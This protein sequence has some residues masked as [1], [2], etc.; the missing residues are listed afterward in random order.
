MQIAYS[1][2][3]EY[4]AFDF[5]PDELA[6]RLTMIGTAVERITPLYERFSGVIIGRVEQVEKHRQQTHLSI[7]ALNT[8][9]GRC[10]VVC[11]APN[12]HPGQYSPYAPPGARLPGGKTVS[13]AEIAGVASAGFLCSEAEMGLSEEGDRL[14]V[15]DPEKAEAGMDVWEFLAL[16]DWT[17]QFELTPN[18]PDC[19]SA[20]GIAREI[21]A[22]AGTKLRRPTVDVAEGDGP[23]AERVKIEIADREGCP[24]YAA[25]VIDN[26]QIAPSPF[27]LKRR[28]HSAGIRAINNIVDITNYVMMETGQPLHA[29]DLAKFKKP[30]VVVRAARNGEP[31]ATLDGETRRLSADAV[32]ITD[33]KDAVA[34]GGVMG[35][36]DSE[37]SEETKTVLLESAYF[38]PI[39]IRRT[40]KFLGLDTESAI[41]FEK[42]VDPNGVDFALHRAAALLADLAGGQVLSGAVDCY[43]EPIE[44]LRINVRPNRVNKLIGID[45]ASPKM[46]DILSSLEFGVAAGKTIAV[47]VPT[48]RPDVTREVDLI[49][50]IARISNYEEI[51]V[52]RQA[53]GRIPTPT[54]PTICFEAKLREILAGEGLYEV[55]TNSLVD[56]E[57]LEQDEIKQAIRIKNPLSEELSVMRTS[58]CGPLLAVVAH[59]LNRQVQT[60]RIFE[61]GRVFRQNIEK[62]E[63]R[64]AMALMLVG[65][66]PT[67][68]WES[69]LR[70]TDF[71]D[72]KGILT[73]FFKQLQI[74]IDFRPDENPLF[75][76]RASFSLGAG[77]TILGCMGLIDAGL[78]RRHEV[79][80]PVWAAFLDFEKLERMAHFDALYDA[81]PR[82]PRSERDCAV[83]VDRSVLA[84]Q[85]V[86]AVKEAAPK[87][88]EEVE[89]FDIYRGR[90]I[91]PDKKSVAI[92]IAYR[93]IDRTLTDQ[94]VNATH[95][96]IV[97]VLKE[98]FKAKLRD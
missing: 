53:A 19:L 34:I 26:I 38:N 2:L 31:F 27:W 75:A 43:P 93:A 39:R 29:F 88:I 94:Q 90:P 45:L 79:K 4:I 37:V 30:Q 54:N 47:T 33:G 87:L 42:G 71:Y 16:D 3:K 21:G 23:A 24:R 70:T 96:K 92:S 5:S 91:P 18:R 51:P 61:I 60:V 73:S 13:M 28:L 44:P 49:E 69:R 41:R 81:V 25:R 95:A 55:I 1:W 82:F 35:G 97:S 77:E 66:A 40:R 22:L 10:T 76:P 84:G 36:R 6:D 59:N 15:L 32:M 78:A 89:I 8:G 12:V 7:C 64:R 86:Q 85:L 74:S 68:R 17:L 48:F 46:I 57:G 14:M 65:N 83:I 80:V 72:I 62:H 50:E 98:Q 20:L 11:G 56:P 52:K 63:E 58:L 67:T 9:S